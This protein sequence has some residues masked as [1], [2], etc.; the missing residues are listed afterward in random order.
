MD[1]E[2]RV[3]SVEEGLTVVREEQL[4]ALRAEMERKIDDVRSEG[5]GWAAIAVQTDRKVDGASEIINLI[6]KDVRK[7]SED[8]AQVKAIQEQH[9]VRLD[10]IEEKVDAI[11]VKL[12]AQGDTLQEI[13]AQ[14][15]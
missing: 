1:L 11:D 9:G 3:T 13:L 5:R 2:A 6:Y 10:A 15:S 4:P 8:I 14:L 7:T 12:V